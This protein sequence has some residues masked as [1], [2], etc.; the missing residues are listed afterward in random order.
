LQRKIERLKDSYVV[1]PLRLAIDLAAGFRVA[2]IVRKLREAGA[3]ISARPT[4]VNGLT[5]A[6]RAPPAA[7]A[8]GGQTR[9]PYKILVDRGGNGGNG[10]LRTRRSCGTVVRGCIG[11]RERALMRA[12]AAI[13]RMGIPTVKRNTVVTVAYS[14]ELTSSSIGD[15]SHC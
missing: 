15:L 5:S 11:L 8:A 7:G 9:N 14:L 2:F 10:R 3:L 6:R 12:Q 4:S 1:S 13:N